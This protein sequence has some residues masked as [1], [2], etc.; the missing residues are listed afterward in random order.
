MF[1]PKKMAKVKITISKDKLYKQIKDIG[2]SGLLHVDQSHKNLFFLNL[3]NKTHI[4]LQSAQKYLDILGI[5]E[6]S[7]YKDEIHSLEDEIDDCEEA[8]KDIGINI[9]KL[10]NEK[11]R[12]EKI[13]KELKTA[14][15]I[16]IA[17]DELDLESLNALKMFDISIAVIPQKFLE[18][19]SLLVKNY[20]SF[21]V[22]SPLTQGTIAIAVFYDNKNKENINMIFEKI[23]AQ[24][25]EMIY[26]KK[27]YVQDIYKMQSQLDEEFDEIKKEYKTILLEQEVKLNTIFKMLF[28]QSSLINDESGYILYGWVPYNKKTD[29]KHQLKNSIVE[30]FEVGAT[31]PVLLKTPKLFQPFEEL[32]ENFSYPSYTEIN[33]TVIFAFT[34]LIMFGIMFGDIGH[35]AVL[36]GLGYSIL[37]YTTKHNIL[38]KIMVSTGISAMMFGLLYGSIFG[39]HHILPHLLFSPMEDISTILFLSLVVGVFIITLSITLNIF[40]K[41]KQKNFYHLFFGSGGLLWLLVYWFII[42]IAVKMSLYNLSVELELYILAFILSIMFLMFL[43]KSKNIVKTLIETAMEIMEYATNT[44]SF[45]RLGAFTLSHAA[46]F[47]ALF[48]IADIISKSTQEGFGYWL[49]IIIGNIIIIVLEGVVVAIQTLR[50]EYYEFF[51]RFY[52][53][54]GEKYKPFKLREEYDEKSIYV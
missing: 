49:T 7:A 25:I 10:S 52:K 15:K 37:Q 43:Y 34:F 9:E 36:S 23:E 35:G 12:I 50:L 5:Q 13:L 45:I 40:S 28:L 19:F 26:F 21:I 17:L 20:S 24:I 14:Q 30:F 33:P 16:Q 51:K 48:A 41:F 54:G 8:L 39:F 31:A 6:R 2:L 3:Q 4:L 44:V 11:D 53:G 42:G 1:F 46:L 47:T 22:T 38:A 18:L 27:K 29:F 32:I